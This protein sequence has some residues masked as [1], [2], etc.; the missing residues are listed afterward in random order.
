M[1]AGRESG[2]G[3]PETGPDQGPCVASDAMAPR[4]SASHGGWGSRWNRSAGGAR[5][6]IDGRPR[7]GKGC[8]VSWL[9]QDTL[10]QSGT[11]AQGKAMEWVCNAT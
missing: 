2:T 6:L 7:E 5:A 1:A 9:A 3:C 4:L 8:P 11:W 10:Q